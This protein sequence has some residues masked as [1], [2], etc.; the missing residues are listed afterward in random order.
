MYD[1]YVKSGSARKIY[2]ST[3]FR[4]FVSHKETICRIVS[5]LRHRVITGQNKLKQVLTE[6][7]LDEI[8]ARLEYTS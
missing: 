8:G 5:K 4:M 1:T 2:S 3:N 7:K 6:E